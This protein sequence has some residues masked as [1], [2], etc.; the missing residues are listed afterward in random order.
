VRPAFEIRERLEQDGTLCLKL[1]GELDLATAAQLKAHLRLCWQES[2][3]VRLDLS[4]LGFLDSS[5]LVA[6]LVSLQQAECEGSQLQVLA[7]VSPQT[8][9]VIDIAGVAPF[10]WPTSSSESTRAD[11]QCVGT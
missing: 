9:R 7:Q 10:L 5:G 1:L 8:Q 4:E 11:A 3:C 2:E 6:I